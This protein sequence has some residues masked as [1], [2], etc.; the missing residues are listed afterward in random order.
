MIID[1]QEFDVF[2]Q[3]MADNKQ[4]KPLRETLQDEWFL[5]WKQGTVYGIPKVTTPGNSFG[6]PTKLQTDNYLGL[7]VLARAQV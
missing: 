7:A 4:L 1:P 5:T 2:K 6:L 3:D